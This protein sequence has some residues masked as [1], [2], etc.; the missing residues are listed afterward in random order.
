MAASDYFDSEFSVDICYW[1]I[2][3]LVHTQN[4][5]IFKFIRVECRCLGVLE[6]IFGRIC[7]VLVISSLESITVIKSVSARCK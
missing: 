7:Y 5:S 2:I 1:E 4:G 6:S 3:V